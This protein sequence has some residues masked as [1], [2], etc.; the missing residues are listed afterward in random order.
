MKFIA[1][2]LLSLI[3]AG[4]AHAQSISSEVLAEMNLAR[5]APQQYAQLLAQRMANYKGR[6]GHRVVEEAVRFLQRA[7]PLP[8]LSLSEGMSKAASLHV[9]DQG[10]RGARGHRGSGGTSPWGRMA[11][12]GQHLGYA[13]ENI[14]Y[15]SRDARGIV[16]ALIVDDGVRGRGHRKNI[17]SRNFRV[18]GIAAGPHSSYRSMCVMGFASGFIERGGD[19]VA[20]STTSS[21]PR[22]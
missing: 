12:F 3:L 8:A 6:E 18:T 20:S 1:V 17:F 10:S 16:M 11:R 9:A 21:L 2:S 19:R 15:G 13:G 5:T 14:H 7:E 22:L 4:A